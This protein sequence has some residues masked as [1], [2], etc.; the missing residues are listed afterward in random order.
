MLTTERKESNR[1]EEEK[2]FLLRLWMNFDLT[3][4]DLEPDSNQVFKLKSLTLRYDLS[5][6]HAKKHVN[7]SCFIFPFITI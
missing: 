6:I 3:C 1:N 2:K 4:C 5:R 7:A